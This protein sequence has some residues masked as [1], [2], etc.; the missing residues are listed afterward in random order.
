MKNLGV[1]SYKE[2]ITQEH[3]KQ[4]RVMNKLFVIN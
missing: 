1:I 4:E 3:G 2:I